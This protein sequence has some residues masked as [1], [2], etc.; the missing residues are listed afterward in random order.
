MKHTLLEILIF[1]LQTLILQQIRSFS[2]HGT[3]LFNMTTIWVHC[4]DKIIVQKS[5]F[6]PH[7]PTQNLVTDVSIKTP[8]PNFSACSIEFTKYSIDIHKQSILVE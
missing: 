4:K 3:S 5:L 6:K 2:N 7:V 1:H 8:T